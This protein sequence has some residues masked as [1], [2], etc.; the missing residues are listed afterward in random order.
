MSYCCR[1]ATA[2][3]LVCKVPDDSAYKQD[4]DKGEDL[5]NHLDNWVFCN[6]RN[7]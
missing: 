4:A 2:E 5:V 7:D 6:L 1:I 3:Q